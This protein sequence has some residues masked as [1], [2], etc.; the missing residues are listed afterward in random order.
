[1]LDGLRIRLS[2]TLFVHSHST[3]ELVLTPESYTTLQAEL[4]TRIDELTE[5]M[6]VLQNEIEDPHQNALFK[7]RVKLFSAYYTDPIEF[8]DLIEKEKEHE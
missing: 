3:D 2:D 7:K 1:M 6:S 4:E 8:L 5:R